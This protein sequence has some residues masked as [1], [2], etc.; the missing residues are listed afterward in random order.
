M[1]TTPP[2]LSRA[3]SSSSVTSHQSGTIKEHWNDLPASMVS[4]P[5]RSLT[6]TPLSSAPSPCPET[7]EAEEFP[8]LLETLFA[9]TP[10]TLPERERKMLHEKVLKS[11]PAITPQ[12][13]REVAEIVRRLLHEKS[14]GKKEAKEAVVAFIM[15]ERGVAGWAGG[16]RRGVE[17]V[18][19]E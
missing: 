2:L 8:A 7:D 1:F 9:G 17:N 6:S 16:V 14:L 10:T 11:L 18:V 15:R 19:L 5:T 4:P 13:K 3:A 12:Q